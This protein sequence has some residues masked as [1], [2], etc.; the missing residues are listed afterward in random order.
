VEILY[1]EELHDLQSSA[2]NRAI[3][4]KRMNGTGDVAGIRKKRGA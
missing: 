4:S 1:N 2:K 3:R